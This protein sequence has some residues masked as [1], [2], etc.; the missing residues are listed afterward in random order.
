LKTRKQLYSLTE[1]ALARSDTEKN[2]Q[3]QAYEEELNVRLKAI[4]ALKDEVHALKTS[5]IWRMTSKLRSVANL[6]KGQKHTN[7]ANKLVSEEK[8]LRL[9]HDKN[10]LDN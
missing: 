3:Q 2:Q 6:I 7:P 5:R 1:D 9:T 4:L 10:P 8:K